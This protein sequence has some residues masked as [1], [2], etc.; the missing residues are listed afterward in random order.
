MHNTNQLLKIQ[1][2]LEE[3]FNS[4]D[5]QYDHQN[6]LAWYYT[7][8]Y[9]RPCCTPALIDEIQQWYGHLTNLENNM[10][11]PQYIAIASKIRGVFNLGGDLKLFAQYIR[12]QNREALLSYAM[13]CIDTL[14]L[15]H[16]GLGKNI[17]TI[18]LV[19]GDALGG[20]FEFAISSN[21]LIAER[22]A[23]M[24]MP[25]ILFNLF[26]GMGAYSLLSR[27]IGSGMAEK[28]ILGGKLYT[29][30][31]MYELGIVD[32][33]A[34]DGEGEKAVF[35]YIKKQN[36]ASNGYRAFQ[37]A[38]RHCN[39]VTYEELKNIAIIWADAALKLSDKDLR[40]MERLV[41]R[42]SLKVSH[43]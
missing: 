27:K 16:T 43:G 42:Q 9:P 35:E 14:Y 1:P 32:V 38:K 12:S 4:L 28:M 21:V 11:P 34:E 37:Q 23:K 18:S 17:T 5:I 33:L 31:E 15:N 41:A 20:G 39:P 26:P 30:E 19:Q 8:P 3:S 7:Q 10:S 29:A 22:S 6:S 2:T 24:G 40:M 25:E 36:R 13:S